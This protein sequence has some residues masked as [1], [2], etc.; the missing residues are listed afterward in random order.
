MLTL[1]RI[2]LAF[3]AAVLLAAS[4]SALTVTRV[5]VATTPT[6]LYTAAPGGS[7]ALIRN[8]GAASV[9]LGTS[10]VTTSTGFELAAGDSIRLP[11]GR[12]DGGD[13]VY[14]I[15]VTSTVVVHVME[16]VK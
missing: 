13:Q 9:Y 11:L 2:G 8:A 1:R 6:L 16:S 15:V 10:A 14:G 5:T 12:V 4:V 7:T 3:A